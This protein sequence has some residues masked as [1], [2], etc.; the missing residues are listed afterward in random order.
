M[1]EMIVFLVVGAST[2]LATGILLGIRG[3]LLPNV[4]QRAARCAPQEKASQP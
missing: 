1:K 3:N 4:C 2:R